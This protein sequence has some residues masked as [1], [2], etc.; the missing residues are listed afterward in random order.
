MK[1]QSIIYSMPTEEFKKLVELSKTLGEILR[2]FGLS[3]KGGNSKTLKKRMDKDNIDYSHIKLG[4]G[5]TAGFS[6]KP[7]KPIE[8]LFIVNSNTNRS[9]IKKRIISENLI[10]YECS[11]CKIKDEWNGKKLVLQLEH[12]NGVSNDNRLENLCFLCPNC[13]SQTSTYA[14]KKHKKP[15]V[16]LGRPKIRLDL[17]KVTWPTKE[18]LEKLVWEI[19]SSDVA[20]IYGVSDTTIVKWCKK[21]SI[22][23]PPVG[24]WQKIKL[25]KLDSN[26]QLHTSK[27]RD[28]AD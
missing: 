8:E 19:P 5:S 17:R 15:K 20:K 10:K 24:Y 3:N 1:K 28:L 16:K 9:T 11:H 22:S 4:V 14:G 7:K 23:K 27:V 2:H 6:F 25:P 13:H 18:E 26:Q 12:I 21:Y